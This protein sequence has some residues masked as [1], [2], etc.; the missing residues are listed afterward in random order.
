[1][2]WE[3]R[4]KGSGGVQGKGQHGGRVQGKGMH[5]ERCTEQGEGQEAAAA[6]P[7]LTLTG[8]RATATAWHGQVLHKPSRNKTRAN[9]KVSRGGGKHQRG[10]H[11]RAE[12]TGEG[13]NK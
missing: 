13:D 8:A 6:T 10:T 2:L 4:G 7:A 5:G 1:M 12:G 11:G 3:H 9:A